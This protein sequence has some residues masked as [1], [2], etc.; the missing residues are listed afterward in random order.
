MVNVTVKIKDATNLRYAIAMNGM[1]ENQLSLNIG[2]CRQYI[3]IAFKKGFMS[4]YAAVKITEKTGIIFS[5]YFE[6]IEK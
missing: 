2:K 4:P 6:L 1:S 5:D 3:H